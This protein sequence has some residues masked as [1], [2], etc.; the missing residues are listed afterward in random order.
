[1]K[2]LRT[3]PLA[4][5]LCRF[6]YASSRE[7]F[8]LCFALSCVGTACRDINI[9]DINTTCSSEYSC[10]TPL[11][12]VN[13]QCVQPAAASAHGGGAG[14]ND[15]AGGFVN[16]GGITFHA[17]GAPLHAS[18]A[19]G[20]VASSGGTLGQTT[21]DGGA[22]AT[23]GG[24]SPDD[25]SIPDAGSGAYVTEAGGSVSGGGA[26]G[27]QHALGGLADD[28][29]AAGQMAGG[30][31][32]SGGNQ[33]VGA[34]AG[35]AGLGVA[36]STPGMDSPIGAACSVD[37]E[38]HSTHCVDNV[39]CERACAGQCETCAADG[40]VGQC[41]TVL[42]GQ[43]RGIRKPCAHVG[44]LCGGKCSG[45]R[46]CTYPDSSQ[47]CDSHTKCLSSTE[48]MSG[49]GCDGAG[50]CSV[51]IRSTCPGKQVCNLNTTATCGAAVYTAVAVSAGHSCAV[52][53]DGTV[54]CWG[55]P[56]NGKL[57]PSETA[58]QFVPMRIPNQYNIKRVAV[59][60]GHTCTLAHDGAV[61]CWGYDYNGNLGCSNI[62]GGES[63][64]VCQAL[65]PGN[66]IVDIAAGAEHSCILMSS[67][68][69]WCWG[70]NDHGQVGDGRLASRFA[71]VQV[72][73]ISDAIAIA[74]GTWQSCARR[75][76]GAVVCWGKN[77]YCALGFETAN[78]FAIPV[79][80]GSVDGTSPRALE[81]AGS[82]EQTC[83]LLDDGSLRCSGVWLRYEPDPMSHLTSCK[84]P[85][86]PQPSIIAKAVATG[87]DFTC[88]MTG[89]SAVK[90]WGKNGYGT[91]GNG[92]YV[93]S[94][95]PVDVAFPVSLEL[96]SIVSQGN[97]TCVVTA[98]GQLWCWGDNIDGQLG[99][100]SLV[101]SSAIPV[102]VVAPDF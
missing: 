14:R 79:L 10:R 31:S 38:C 84:A 44:E 94:A 101:T 76:N 52:V 9:Y 11:V 25:H 12:C 70:R 37:T 23:A 96:Q 57:Y 61:T 85:T 97:H 60:W 3:P 74:T 4:A 29:G 64:F 34:V 35:V 58:K 53:S 77:D 27:G 8:A 18:G 7:H 50:S 72:A 91:L 81:V 62:A 1:M 89:S 22:L 90:C 100:G 82:L 36:G 63:P 73:G 15:A 75:R 93:D 87:I 24:T 42:A 68:S 13:S 102:Q 41:T 26:S 17:G 78:D 88:A 83:V 67:G 86:N 40:W 21:A 43:P 16:G 66:S 46:E 45:D 51:P 5:S 71:P 99:S 56:S 19:G 65:G 54:R 92:S 6:R 30:R 20:T 80:F 2:L 49:T 32:V 98:E 95:E 47:V 69:V 55:S 39:C 59:G 33:S 28:A 48:F